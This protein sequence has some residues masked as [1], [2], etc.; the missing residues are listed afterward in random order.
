[1][2]KGLSDTSLSQ[3]SEF[4]ARKTALHFP[5]ERWGDLQRRIS[6]AAKEFGYSDEEAFVQWLVSSPLSSGHIE[7]LA[8][9]LTIPETYFWRES[10]VFQALEEQILPG[11]IDARQNGER[12]LRIWSAGCATGEE[13]YSIAIA[14]RRALPAREGWQVNILATDINPRILRRAQV[15]VYSQWSFRNTPAWLKRDYFQVTGEGRLKIR[16]KIRDGVTFAYLNLAEDVYPTVLN[17]TN[18]MDI[19]FC[20]NVLMYFMPERARRV[21]DNFYRCLLDGG[22]LMV[23]GCELSAQ[24]FSQFRSVHFPGATIYRKEAGGTRPASS[25]G[26][27]EIPPPVA[28]AAPLW[29]AA[30][31]T[32]WPAQPPRGSVPE[33]MPTPSPHPPASSASDKALQSPAPGSQPPALARSQDRE[34]SEANAA[35]IRVLANQGHLGA[36]LALC[37][38]AIAADKLDP[39]LHYLRATILQEQ[40]LAE[41]AI[42]S[43]RRALYLEPNLMIAHFALGNLMLRQENPE[44]AKKYFANVMGLLGDCDQ[45]DILPE[46]EGLTVGRF[47]EIIQATIQAGGLA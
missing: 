28:V 14:L 17:F 38:K 45:E 16:P 43:L 7:I 21:V 33:S 20:R 25:L 2:N 34:D 30:P 26:L 19:I 41:E 42:A 1:M 5:P 37:E 39:T 3:L 4:I 13:P 18:A 29:Q 9:H 12:R 36:A 15:G 31:S 35:T 23:G 40:N 10:Q 24:T 46:A 11:L 27:A 44:A 8:S 47:R 6:P 22:W 32:P